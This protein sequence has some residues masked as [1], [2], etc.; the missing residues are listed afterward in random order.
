MGN[1]DKEGFVEQHIAAGIYN[2]TLKEACE[3]IFPK[4][5]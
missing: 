4:N 1:K 3:T 5:G 2:N